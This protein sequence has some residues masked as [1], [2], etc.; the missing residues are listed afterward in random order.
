MRG[1][2]LLKAIALVF[3]GVF[4]ALWAAVTIHRHWPDSPSTA[5]APT[6]AQNAEPRLETAPPHPTPLPLIADPAPEPNLPPSPPLVSGILKSLQLMFEGRCT[7]VKERPNSCVIKASEDFP[8]LV[9]VVSDRNPI[10][11][12]ATATQMVVAFPGRIPDALALAAATLMTLLAEVGGIEGSEIRFLGQTGRR[13]RPSKWGGKALI[14]VE[15]GGPMLL[16]TV[17]APRKSRG[18][19]TDP[20][21]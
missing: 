5:A 9:K 15:N 19:R 11:P 20:S 18:G 4:G 7:R 3:L 8:F 1:W 14:E 17:T 21:R 16:V 2:W 13:Q 12:E 6:V 10:T